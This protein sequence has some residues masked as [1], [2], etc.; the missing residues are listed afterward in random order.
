[1]N[2]LEQGLDLRMAQSKSSKTVHESKSGLEYY[3]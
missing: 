2:G 3:K 1:M